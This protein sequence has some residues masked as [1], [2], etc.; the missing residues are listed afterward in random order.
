M[1]GV[2]AAAHARATLRGWLVGRGHAE[3][4]SIRGATRGDDTG[5][6]FRAMPGW[7]DRELCSDQNIRLPGT[8]GA[9]R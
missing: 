1:P 9:R 6:L 7:T 2:A 3:R 8:R 5:D 4:R